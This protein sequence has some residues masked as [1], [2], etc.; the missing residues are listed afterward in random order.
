[1]T[2]LEELNSKESKWIRINDKWHLS[3]DQY[4]W[5]LERRI[6]GL[7]PVTRKPCVE[8]K[9]TYH[10]DL[11]SVARRINNEDMKECESLREILGVLEENNKL[12][13]K[14]LEDLCD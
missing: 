4:Q 7:A 13:T 8:K 11:A 5:V 14:S 1:M 12:L 10:H 9:K 3:S 2:P 6:E